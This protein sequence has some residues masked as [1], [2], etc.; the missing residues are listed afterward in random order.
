MSKRQLR[1]TELL[2]QL[3]F[4]QQDRDEWSG[5]NEQRAAFASQLI[6]IVEEELRTLRE[7]TQAFN[8][9]NIK[10]WPS[11]SS[12]TVHYNDEYA[13]AVVANDDGSYKC[14]VSMERKGEQVDQGFS[15][16]SELESAIREVARQYWLMNYYPPE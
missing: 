14:A 13:G 7:R 10:S 8:E 1:E 2:Q 15:T 16:V 12:T 11:G 4:A 6:E 9:A 3:E 5:K